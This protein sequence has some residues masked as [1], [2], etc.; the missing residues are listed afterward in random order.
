MRTASIIRR[1]LSFTSGT[2]IFLFCLFIGFQSGYADSFDVK[3]GDDLE[4]VLEVPAGWIV[5]DYTNIIPN[6]PKVEAFLIISEKL[7]DSTRTFDNNMSMQIFRLDSS[8]TLS[9]LKNLS[10]NDYKTKYPNF[11]LQDSGKTLIDST[12]SEWLLYSTEAENSVVNFLSYFVVKHS[13]GIVFS[14]AFDC[15]GSDRYLRIFNRFVDNISW[16]KDFVLV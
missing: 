14:F 10:L 15:Q 6:M 2:A 13:Y 12:N 9:R 7:I 3:I 1:T 8:V 11:K 16:K 5:R 4:F